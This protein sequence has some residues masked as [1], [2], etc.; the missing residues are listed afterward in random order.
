MNFFLTLFAFLVSVPAF[1]ENTFEIRSGNVNFEHNRPD[2]KLAH[3]WIQLSCFDKDGGGNGASDCID[4]IVNGVET[5]TENLLEFP[6]IPG[7]S[8]QVDLSAISIRLN[9]KSEKFFCIG[10]KILFEGFPNKCDSL[11]YPSYP[12]PRS[13]DRYSLL[14]FCSVESIPEGSSANSRFSNRRKL[15]WS[16]FKA[17]LAQPIGIQLTDA[18]SDQCN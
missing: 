4:V 18:T 1:S 5:T 12:D 2:L 17:S 16:D 11:L 10:M 14:S 9:E 3:L 6:A 15:T 8:S 7:S 13:R